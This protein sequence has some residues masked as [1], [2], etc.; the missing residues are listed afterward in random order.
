[1]LQ[2]H[3]KVVGINGQVSLGKALAGK[4]VKIDQIDKCTW[5]IK[6]GEFIPDSQKWL[7]E[8]DNMAKLD[9]ALEWAEKTPTRVDN[10]EEIIKKME[11]VAAKKK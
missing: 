4:I 10:A 1:M 7:S 5:V 3:V 8:G 2:H 9:S 11:T 6:S